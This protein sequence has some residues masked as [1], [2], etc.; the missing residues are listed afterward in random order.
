MDYREAKKIDKRE[1]NVQKHFN[2]VANLSQEGQAAYVHHPD[3]ILG[4]EKKHKHYLHTNAKSQSS[5]IWGWLICIT[6]IV[7]IIAVLFSS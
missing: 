3:Q 7:I 2:Q 6:L 4:K 1:K 5:S